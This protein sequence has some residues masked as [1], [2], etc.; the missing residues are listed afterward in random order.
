MPSQYF[1]WT[2]SN[3]GPNLGGIDVGGGGSLSGGPAQAGGPGGMLGGPLSALLGA[4]GGGL[5]PD[6]L[7]QS[8]TEGGTG[9]AQASPAA[10]Q[11]L[12]AAFLQPQFGTEQTGAGN[13]LL[14]LL[15]LQAQGSPNLDVLQNLATRSQ[16]G[17]QIGAEGG[18]GQPQPGVAGPSP[19]AQALRFAQTGTKLGQA[20]Q[21]LLG[22]TTTGPSGASGVFDPT[23]YG[24]PAEAGAAADLPGLQSV[25]GNQ[26][27]QILRNPSGPG[28]GLTGFSGG[29]E[30]GLSPADV[31]TAA[32]AEGG[33]T[34][35]E[36]GGT[37][38][39]GGAGAAGVG[40]G[41]GG[42]KA[43]LE[44][45]GA[46]KPGSVGSGVLGGGAFVAGAYANPYVAAASVP[47]MGLLHDWMSSPYA[48]ARAAAG[49]DISHFVPE[50][51]HNIASVQDPGQIQTIL[52]QFNKLGGYVRAQTPGS[53]LGQTALGGG[54]ELGEQFLPQINPLLQA[55]IQYRLG[56]GGP[57]EAPP[58]TPKRSTS[59]HAFIEGG[60]G[61]QAGRPFS[62]FPEGVDPDWRE[63]SRIGR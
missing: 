3:V 61:D 7:G 24:S 62:Y 15:G 29:Q 40:A 20:G 22:A 41:L 30:G 21:S 19:L 12:L 1:P 31:G 52:E 34:G 37:L 32:T 60:G 59:S 4:A 13:P 11:S 54:Y 33:A 47:V 27:G 28:V 2:L 55:L 25:V 44:A 45:T 26:P 35:A 17:G 18:F 53:G 10:F 49:V 36:V 6:M 57:T 39:G 23:L 38:G 63:E 51:L 43:I 8:L 48:N 14:Q 58:M 50:L 9:S 56:G 5:G 16:T 46:I 42:L